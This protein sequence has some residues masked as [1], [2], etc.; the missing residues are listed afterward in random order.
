MECDFVSA[1]HALFHGFMHSP[2]HNSMCKGKRMKRYFRH[3]LS[4]WI[5]R[6]CSPLKKSDK[7]GKMQRIMGKKGMQMA[8]PIT[9]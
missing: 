7:I 9:Y 4:K 1:T 5:R 3:L 8:T 6:D 2:Q